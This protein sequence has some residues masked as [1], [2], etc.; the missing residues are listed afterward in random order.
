MIFFVSGI[1]CCAL[2]GFSVHISILC[3]FEVSVEIIVL[4]SA[5]MMPSVNIELYRMLLSYYN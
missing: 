2:C 4:N 3:E 5:H 1:V